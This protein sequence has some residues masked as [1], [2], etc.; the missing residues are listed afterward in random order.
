M[1]DIPTPPS[2][3]T[4]PT[5]GVSPATTS[6]GIDPKL[7]GLLAYLA[8]WL[9]GLI[10]YL[11][12]KEHREVRFHAAQ[13]VLLSIALV[14]VWIVLGVLSMIP[15]LG[16]IFGLFGFLLGLASVALW[17]YLLVKGYQLE[18]VR[19]PVVG[20]MAEKWAAR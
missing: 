10:L 5:G 16:L 4:P 9:S 13:S 20:K 7:A 1:S 12:E 8:G 19:L 6:M 17:V 3:P 2:E 11:V 14:A 18:H 15:V